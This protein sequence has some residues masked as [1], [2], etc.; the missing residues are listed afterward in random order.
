MN[1]LFQVKR[2]ENKVDFIILIIRLSIATLMIFHGLPKLN[3]L[4]AGGEIQF[5]DP[6]GVGSTFS[7]GLAVFAEV[8]CSFLIAIGL[9]TRLASIPLIITMLVAVFVVHGADPIDVKEMAILY[10]LFYLL[11]FVTGSGKFSI[12]NFISKKSRF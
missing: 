4:L 6:L 12:D 3:T 1:R 5:P 10:L 7:L 11:L 2:S 9:A 8:V